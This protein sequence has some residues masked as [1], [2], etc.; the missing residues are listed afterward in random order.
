MM[1]LDTGLNPLP[2]K[3]FK[4]FVTERLDHDLV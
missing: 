2:K 3:R 1:G 4:A